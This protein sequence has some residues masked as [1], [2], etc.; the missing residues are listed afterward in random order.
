[1]K[2]W[3]WKNGH[4]GSPRCNAGVVGKERYFA[5]PLISGR[6]I[7]EKRNIAVRQVVATY[8][9][10]LFLTSGGREE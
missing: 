6:R 2:L 8:L 10:L 4:C 3:V 5:C 7:D 9:F 1:M